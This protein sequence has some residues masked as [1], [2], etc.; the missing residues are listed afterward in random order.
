LT[1]NEPSSEELAAIG[2]RIRAAREKAGL[3]VRELARRI[4]VSASHVSQAER[5]LASFSVR[6]LYNVVS[7][8]GI[9]MDSLFDDS[10]PV[11]PAA[12]VTP[13]RT[14]ATLDGPLVDSG[15]VLRAERRPSIPLAGGTRWER[16]TP[17]PETGAEFIEVVYP[18]APPGGALVPHDYIRHSSREYGVVVAGVL[19][20]QVGFD[21]TELRVGD[22]IAFDSVVPHRFWNETSDEV[23]AIWFIWDEPHPGTSSDGTTGGIVAHSLHSLGADNA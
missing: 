12:A 4:E 17:R 21:Q 10:S 16:L 8:L 18:P 15:I 6:A 14:A 11:G 23:R 19:T 7:E 20:V 13:S 3:S 5:G 1:I 22:S 2:D 9:S